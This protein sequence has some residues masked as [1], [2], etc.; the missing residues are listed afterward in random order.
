M[1]SAIIWQDESKQTSEKADAKRT[2][3]PAAK[4]V[5]VANVST[6]REAPTTSRTSPAIAAEAEIRV[7]KKEPVRTRPLN[8]HVSS[9]V[10]TISGVS[11]ALYANNSTRSNVLTVL[12]EG[13]I[14]EPDLQIL[15]AAGSWTLVRIPTLN[16]FGFVQ[17]GNLAALSDETAP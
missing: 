5:R 12:R 2:A 7:S 10:L 1:P 17:T 13:T 14:I 9:K 15:D 16:I 8:S 11:A 4:S 3:K 6:R